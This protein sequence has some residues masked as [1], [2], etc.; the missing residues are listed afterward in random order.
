[1]E[2]IQADK[3][4]VAVTHNDYAEGSLDANFGGWGFTPDKTSASDAK[5][6]LFGTILGV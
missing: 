1:M 6:K 3:D 5:A 4:A 2:A